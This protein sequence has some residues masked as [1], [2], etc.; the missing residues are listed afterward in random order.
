MEKTFTLTITLTSPNTFDVMFDEHESGETVT[1]SCHD[2]G[3][4]VSQ[5]NTDLIN[6]IRSWVSLMR[7]EQEEEQEYC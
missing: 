4:Y 5:E 3:K 2:A 6:E 1:Y 7:D